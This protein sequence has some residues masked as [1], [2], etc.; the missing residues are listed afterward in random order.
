MSG[1]GVELRWS[2][3]GN[4]TATTSAAWPGFTRP[5]SGTTNATT[6]FL[7]YFSADG[8]GNGIQGGGTPVAFANTNYNMLRWSDAGNGSW[9]S[10]PNLTAYDD[11]THTTPAS[12]NSSAFPN[13]LAGNTN[14]TGATARSY[15]KAN[16][17]GYFNQTPGAAP[18]NAPVV[19]DGT[20]GALTPGTAAW[21]TNYQGDRKSVV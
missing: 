14:D 7:Y 4:Q 19:T 15:L 13:N 6:F 10:M 17:Y 12:R 8:T 20:T 9:A 3:Q 11:T 5:A 18:T 21:L 2:D 1:T 16:A